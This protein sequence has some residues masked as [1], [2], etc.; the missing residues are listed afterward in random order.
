MAA[1]HEKGAIALTSNK[2]ARDWPEICAGDEI[3]TT[4]ILDRL[5]HHVVVI[6]IDGR[7]YRLRELDALLQAGTPTSSPSTSKGGPTKT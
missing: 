4:A 7:S 5:L 6:H 2:P 1:R 3:L